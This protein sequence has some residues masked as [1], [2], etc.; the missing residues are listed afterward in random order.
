MVLSQGWTKGRRKIN[1][2]PDQNHHEVGSSWK[3]DYMVLWLRGQGFK[4][5]P[6]KMLPA[7]EMPKT[8]KKIVL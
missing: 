2:N 5:L 3:N 8:Q 1:E 6:A 7:Y 4:S